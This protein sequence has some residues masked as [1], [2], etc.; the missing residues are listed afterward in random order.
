[1]IFKDGFDIF[2]A[3]LQ[4]SLIGECYHLFIVIRF[5]MA[6]PKLNTLS[7]AC[8]TEQLKLV[9]KVQWKPVHVITLGQRETDNINRMITLTNQALRLVDCKALNLLWIIL[10][11]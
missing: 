4:K 3:S 9:I 8:C 7:G 11:N 6:W 5:R 10:I 1:M 2:T